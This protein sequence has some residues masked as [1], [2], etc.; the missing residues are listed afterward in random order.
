[1]PPQ[2]PHCAGLRSL[3]SDNITRNFAESY[4][5]ATSVRGLNCDGDLE[6]R[7]IVF[8]AIPY[9]PLYPLVS[10]FQNLSVV[11]RPPLGQQTRAPLH[12]RKVL[13]SIGSSYDGASLSAGGNL[14]LEV[15]LSLFER[16]YLR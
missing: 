6:S 3:P 15:Q 13:V 9:P 7:A 16:L 11:L 8:V 14:I 1:M 12:Q 2:K 5:L 10:I 4:I